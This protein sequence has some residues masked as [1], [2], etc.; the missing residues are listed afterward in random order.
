[1]QFV[2][3]VAMGGAAVDCWINVECEV[4]I[5]LKKVTEFH[6]GDDIDEADEDRRPRPT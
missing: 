6:Q 5:D 2:R 4:A 1:M 3:V